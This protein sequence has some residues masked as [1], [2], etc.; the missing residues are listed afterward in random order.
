MNNPQKKTSQ[1]WQEFLP[2]PKVLDPDGW[3]RRNFQFSWYE[4]LI[5]FKEYKNRVFLSTV[6]GKINNQD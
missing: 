3:D 2:N 4:E 6:K 1:D 5:T